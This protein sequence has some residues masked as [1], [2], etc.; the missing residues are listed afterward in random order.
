MTAPRGVLALLGPTASGKTA[1][2]VSLAERLGGEVLSADAFAVYRGL[3]AGTAK[4]TAAER[5]GVPHH[6]VDERDPV[7]AW[8]AGEFAREA[9]TRAREVLSRGRLPILCGGTGFYVHAFFEGL[10]EG[11]RR[12]PRIR[13]ALALVAAR[14][15]APFLRKALGLLD[16]EIAA[17]VG[18]NDAVRAARFLEVVLVSGRRPTDLFRERPGEKWEGPSVRLYLSLP[19]PL[20][21]ERIS[22]RFLGSMAAVLPAEVRGLLDMGVPPTAAAFAAIGYRETIELLEGRLDSTEWGETVLRATR[23]FAK[24]QETW[25]RAE[26]GLVRIPAD[27]PEILEIAIAAA[28]PLFY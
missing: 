7:D 28:R 24:R 13:A 23:R 12:D 10:F 25:F 1:L 8:S 26:E 4:P 17:K 20:L 5:R 21:Y 9:R 6:F 22:R 16:P 27:S 15:G 19:R 3:D 18:E 2:A 14:R 11:P